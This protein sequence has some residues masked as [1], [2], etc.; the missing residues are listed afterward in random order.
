ML[1]FLDVVVDNTIFR[2]D[3]K[4]FWK[5]RSIHETV[6][7]LKFNIVDDLLNAAPDNQARIKAME[8]R[9]QQLRELYTVN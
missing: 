7:T 6:I 2:F 5:L 9:M 1:I 4:L 8:D 3:M